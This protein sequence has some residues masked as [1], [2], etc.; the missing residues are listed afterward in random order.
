MFVRFSNKLCVLCVP[1]HTAQDCPQAWPPNLKP[2]R[3]LSLLCQSPHTLLGDVL[4]CPALAEAVPTQPPTAVAERMELRIISKGDAVRS[5]AARGQSNSSSAEAHMCA[6]QLSAS[7][8][9]SCT[10]PCMLLLF[11]VTACNKQQL[12]C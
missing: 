7:L 6:V 11:H 3:L 2:L 12:S 9:I 5:T 10:A 1:V 4:L 8:L